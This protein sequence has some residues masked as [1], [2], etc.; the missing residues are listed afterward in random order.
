MGGK[1]DGWCQRCYMPRIAEVYGKDPK[2]LPFDFPEVLAAIAPRPLY[3]HA[4]RG[5]SN[6]I[7]ASVRRCVAAATDVY[8]LLGA[9]ENILAVYPEGGHGFPSDARSAAYEFV[10][11]V[12]KGTG[13]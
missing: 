2:R 6:F 3:I 8:A 11:R 9:K 5:D 1:L 10:D 13:R 12:L 4:P 7:V